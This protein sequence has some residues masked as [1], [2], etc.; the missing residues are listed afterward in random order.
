[1]NNSRAWWLFFARLVI[2]TVVIVACAHIIPGL[3]VKDLMD[4]IF[5][6]LILGL[7]NS[8]I[9]PIL[10]FLT[11]PISIITLG[12]FSLVINAFTFWLASEIAYG[13]YVASI[14]GAVIGGAIVWV[15]GL[16]TNRFIWEKY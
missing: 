2:T 3:Q 15:T 5:F 8:S 4:T 16:L 6:G 10:V 13:V 12:L 9:R 7:V 1:M 14:W 11:L